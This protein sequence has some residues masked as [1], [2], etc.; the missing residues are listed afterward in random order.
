MRE[1]KEQYYAR[2]LDLPVPALDGMTP[3]DAARTKQG[4][5]QVDVLLKEMENRECRLPKEERFDFS[6]IR[7][8]LG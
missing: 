5:R 2:W 3:R 4:R 1:F 8:E 7:R 6:G